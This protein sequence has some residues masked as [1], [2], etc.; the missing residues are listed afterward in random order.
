MTLHRL[1]KYDYFGKIVH[2]SD[3][4]FK[5]SFLDNILTD[6]IARLVMQSDE[7]IPQQ[8]IFKPNSVGIIQ[9]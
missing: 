1:I 5:S 7:P 2:S 9:P 8:V 6:G 3:C 4:Q